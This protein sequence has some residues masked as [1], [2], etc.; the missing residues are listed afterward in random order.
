MALA[1]VAALLA[2]W[3]NKV[4][5]VD[6]DLEAP[7][8]E[9]FFEQPPSKL[10]GSRA[11]TPGILDLILANQQGRALD[12]RG[13]LLMALPFQPGTQVAI[14]TAGQTSESYAQM[15]QRLDWEKQFAEHKLGRYLDRLREEWSQ[16]YDFVLI[17][18]RTGINDIGGICTALIPDVLILFFTTNKQNLDG[19]IDVARRART[20]QS[21]LPVDRARLLAVPVPSRDESQSEYGEA[22]KWRG[23]F[24]REFADLYRD[25]IPATTTPAEVLKKLYIP[26]IAIWS[27]GERLPVVEKEDEIGDPRSISHAYN[28]LAALIA[29]RLDWEATQESAAI[30]EARGLATAET[31]RREK[32]TRYWVAAVSAAATALVAAFVPLLLPLLQR[33]VR[34]GQGPSP[35]ALVRP[36]ARE[37][38]VADLRDGKGRPIYDFTL[39]VDV[40]TTLKERI[41]RVTYTFNNPTFKDKVQESTEPSDGFAVSYRGWGCLNLVTINVFFKD[42]PSQERPFNMCEALGPAP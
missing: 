12:W 31:R 10:N 7:G 6:W 4:L 35:G 40:P 27:F 16:E 13:C 5:V 11:K 1:N 22:E 21:S 19:V 36:M 38:P 32:R 28:R 8:I 17:D 15:V 33:W 23:I 25:W 29:K 39:W 14:I 20:V 9:K 34:D 42:G 18:S 37:V 41:Q 2:K 3:G 30:A 24:A 26:Y